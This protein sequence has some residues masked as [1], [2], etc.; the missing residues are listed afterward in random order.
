MLSS[1]DTLVTLTFIS[2]TLWNP[3]AIAKCME[4]LVAMLDALDL[5]EKVRYPIICTNTIRNTILFKDTP[6]ILGTTV[7]IYQLQHRVI[8]PFLVKDF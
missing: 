1:I 5:P 3:K 4:S 6:T 2:P 7:V 8:R